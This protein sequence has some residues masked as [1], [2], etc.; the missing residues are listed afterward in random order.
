MQ[1]PQGFVDSNRP[2]NICKL[3]K[4]IYGLKQAPR[5]WFHK[6][7]DFLLQLGFHFSR[8]D[9]SLLVYT[10]DVVQLYLLI[11]IDDLLLTGNNTQTM[12]ILL[13]D[14]QNT[15]DLKQLGQVSIFIVIQITYTPTGAFLHQTHYACDILLSSSLDECKSANTLISPAISKNVPNLT[16]Y[17]NPTHYRQLA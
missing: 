16:P 7:T 12:N 2:N 1:Q 13:R 4:A 5:Q 11:Y 8:A 6:L 17:D 9:P 3:H 10:R 14:L 15:F